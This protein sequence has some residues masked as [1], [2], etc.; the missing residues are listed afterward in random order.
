MSNFILIS[1]KYSVDPALTG[2]IP[3]N[4]DFITSL[5]AESLTNEVFHGLKFVFLSNIANIENGCT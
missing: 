4:A 3:G 1:F 2:C 5:K